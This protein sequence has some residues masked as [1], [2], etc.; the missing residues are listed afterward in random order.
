MRPNS[1]YLDIL[2][3]KMHP[4]EILLTGINQLHDKE[5]E[6]GY[7]QQDEAT[8]HSAPNTLNQIHQYFGQRII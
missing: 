4:E 7:L 6:F 8:S 2:I 1:T 3:L 5:L